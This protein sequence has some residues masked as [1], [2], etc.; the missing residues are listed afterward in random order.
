[1]TGR[2]Q[3]TINIVENTPLRGESKLD[4]DLKSVN[5]TTFMKKKK[6]LV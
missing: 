2:L 3:R 1:M 5:T 6:K 4:L